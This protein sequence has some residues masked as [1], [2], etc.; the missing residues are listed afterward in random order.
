MKVK[1]LKKLRKEAKRKIWVA[2]YYYNDSNSRYRIKT[3][4]A[5]PDHTTTANIKVVVSSD[6]IFERSQAIEEC[7]ILRRNYILDKVCSRR[8]GKRVY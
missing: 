1:L 5:I 6:A 7:N 3:I 8:T 4:Q 2:Y